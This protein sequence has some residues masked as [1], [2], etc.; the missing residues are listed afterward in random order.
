MATQLSL[1]EALAKLG[2]TPEEVRDTLKVK[3]I[4]GIPK[5]CCRCPVAN[6][7]LA[8]GFKDP[9]V[10][11]LEVCYYDGSE[12]TTINTPQPIREFIGNFD[13]QKEGYEC[14]LLNN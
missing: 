7:L 13:Y 8:E 4:K 9:G 1:S 5:D 10:D 3:G 14:L 11:G 2:N 12:C 6:Y